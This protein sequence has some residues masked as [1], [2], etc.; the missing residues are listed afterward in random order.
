M[1]DS[2]QLSI[3]GFHFYLKDN[4]YLMT[5][6]NFQLR[7]SSLYLLTSPKMVASTNFPFSKK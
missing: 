3:N 2:L 5:N 4:Y 6:R 1:E 7:A